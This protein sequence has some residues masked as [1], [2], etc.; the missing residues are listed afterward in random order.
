MLYRL[1][2]LGFLIKNE[3]RVIVS[4]MINFNCVIP[5][6]ALLCCCLCVVQNLL[7][8]VAVCLASQ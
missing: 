4:E 7:P 2:S 8:E 5:A 6:V 1:R 3:V